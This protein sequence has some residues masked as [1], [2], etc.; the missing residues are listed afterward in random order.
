MT[1]L[2]K[3]TATVI[4]GLTLAACGG[5]SDISS[6]TVTPSVSGG[7]G[8]ISPAV[9]FAVP[10]GQSV[11]FVLTPGPGYTS[12]PVDGTCGGTLN[13]NIYTSAAI[14]SDCTVVA[15]FTASSV[16]R[17]FSYET[18]PALDQNSTAGPGDFLALLNQE[19]AKS[20]LFQSSWNGIY[21]L[22]A[23]VN[24]L[25]TFVNDGSGQTY[26]YELL[27]LP[28]N[29][30]DFVTQA[31]AEGAKGYHYEMPV[32][33]FATRTD[34][35]TYYAVYRKDSGVPDLLAQ[36]NQRGQAGYLLYPYPP[37]SF[38]PDLGTQLNNNLYVKNNASKA[39]YVYDVYAAPTLPTTTDSY[40]AQMNSEGAR[41][42]YALA[43][44]SPYFNMP[45][46]MVY[47]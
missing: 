45:S 19:D 18:Q 25:M 21:V 6:Y 17:A 38:T 39:T 10:A 36:A 34:P 7:G 24:S 32:Y 23:G 4:C 37:S 14:T 40:L 3:L 12:G 15:T 47:V 33:S 43:Y 20:Y 31:N 30:P 27:V 5:G 1:T 46:V 11:P 8:T 2:I 29:M 35:V 28:G 9:A 41:G 13:G 22:T 42:Y 26:S 16:A 44:Y